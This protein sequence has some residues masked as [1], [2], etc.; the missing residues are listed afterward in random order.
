MDGGQAWA[1]SPDGYASLTKIM[2]IRVKYQVGK[3]VPN[4]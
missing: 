4:F 1:S 2:W 3:I